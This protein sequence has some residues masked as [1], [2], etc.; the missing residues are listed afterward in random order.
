MSETIICLCNEITKEQIVNAIQE[1][2]LTTTEEVEEATTAGAV[3]GGC[4]PD[5]EDILETEITK[6]Q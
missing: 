3:C 6:R 2:N 4:I 5:I 1:G